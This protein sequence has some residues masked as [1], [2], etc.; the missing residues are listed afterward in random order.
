MSNATTP[1]ARYIWTQSLPLPVIVARSYFLAHYCWTQSLPLPIIVER[2]YFLAHYRWTHSLP[3]SVTVKS[4]HCLCPLLL[5][6]VTAYA[7]YCWTQ[8]L[9]MP[10][11]VERNHCLCPLLHRYEQYL[12]SSALHV[13]PHRLRLGE[14]AKFQKLLLAS[15]CLSVCTGHIGSHWMD[16]CEILCGEYFKKSVE[17]IRVW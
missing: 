9:P 8:S 7:R 12:H 6:A 11:T 4:S 15:S 13:I 16:F 5:N 14:F 10:V 17:I 2:I 1:C 3:V